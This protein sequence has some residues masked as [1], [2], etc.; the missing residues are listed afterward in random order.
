MFDGTDVNTATEWLANLES[1]KSLQVVGRVYSGSGANE[2]NRSSLFLV[3]RK[4][5]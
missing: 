2:L 1:M 5:E 3:Q 4:E